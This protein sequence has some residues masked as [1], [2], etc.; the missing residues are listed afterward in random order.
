MKVHFLGICGTF[1]A[2]LAL[3][4]KQLGY[5]VSGS[6]KGAYPPMSDILDVAGISVTEGY[7]A[8]NFEKQQYDCVVVGNVIS[9]GNPAL[10]MIM[11]L[12]LPYISG[13]QWLFEHVL[14]HKHILAVAGTHGKTTTTALLTW[15][16]EC[17]GLNPGFLIGGDPNDFTVSARV[18]SSN[19]FVIEADEYDTAFYDKRPKFMHYQPRTLVLNNLE[20]DHADIYNNLTEIKQQFSYLLRTVPSNA[21]IILNADDD[22]LQEV[23]DQGCW[24]SVN[25][26]NAE[27]SLWQADTISASGNEFDL[28]YDSELIGRVRWGL[29]GQYNISNALAAATA[30]STL[31]LSASTIVSDISRFKGVAKRLEILFETE[32]ISVYRDFAHHPTAIAGVVSALRKRFTSRR[33]IV[34][35]QLGSRTMQRHVDIEQLAKSL[36]DADS[37]VLLD[38]GEVQWDLELLRRAYQTQ[39]D[40]E[41]SA[42]LILNK[43]QAAI[44]END[45]VVFLS[46]KDFQSIPVRIT[47]Y[48]QQK[49]SDKILIKEG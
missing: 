49:F 32:D 10:E 40:I 12:G 7:R 6:D 8:I 9:R 31:G 20:F 15:I 30:A 11:Q 35:L 18:T 45:C 43:W 21:E 19:Y 33:L 42:A 4:A 1:M 26:F 16:L 46:N 14:K 24:S 47:E 48:L 27:D 37:V 41:S 25:E 38:S 36:S 3:I 39:I 2:G 13:P 44:M 23:I 34:F 5:T 29:L 28:R 17:A 22:N